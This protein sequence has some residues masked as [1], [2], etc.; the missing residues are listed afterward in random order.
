[1]SAAVTA[2][3]LTSVFATSVLSGVLGMAGGMILMAVMLAVLSVPATMVLHGAV[4]GVANGS[5]AW[6][7]REHIA[8]SVLPY[9]CVGAA[10]AILAF[11]L[12]S[13]RPSAPWVLIVLGVVPWIALVVRPLSRLDI[14]QP[15]TA[16][17]CGVLVTGAQLFAGVSGPL[18]DLF[19]LNANLERHGV[20]A[21]KAITQAVG[22]AL[23]L[24]YWGSLLALTDWPPVWLL[25]IA[26]VAAIAGTRVGTRL[27][28]R[29]SQTHFQQ[30]TRLIVLT[31]GALCVV[32]GVSSLLTPA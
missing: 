16:I 6:F 19:Y 21:T 10:L 22:H 28:D 24:G 4:Q 1:M 32:R 27:L 18:L 5:R 15:F 23:K 30:A 13:L 2:L 12:L 29:L 31:I 25:L 9:Y 8:W 14:T 7:L 11:A 20:V 17:V 26:P 3:V